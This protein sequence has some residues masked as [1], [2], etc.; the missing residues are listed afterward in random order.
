M[1]NKRALVL[2]EANAKIDNH[3]LAV[4]IKNDFD[5]VTMSDYKEALSEFGQGKHYDVVFLL[6][7]ED[8]LQITA[9]LKEEMGVQ[10]KIYG[11]ISND[12][13]LGSVFA[14]WFAAGAACAFARPVIFEDIEGT[15]CDD[16]II[17]RDRSELMEL[18][19]LMKPSSQLHPAIIE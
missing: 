2:K 10:T 4:L 14:D 17:R 6:D 19:E 3:L 1:A 12:N 9:C 7:I 18:M 15:L 16:G 5:I 8:G 11:I 13:N